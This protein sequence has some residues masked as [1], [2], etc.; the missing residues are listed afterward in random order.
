MKVLVLAN[1][2]NSRQQS[3]QRFAGLIREGLE[4]AGH[5]VRLVRPPVVLGRLRRCETGLA[6]W[7]GYIDRYILFPPLLRWQKRWADVVHIVADA[8]YIP[9]LHGKPYVLTCHDMLAIRAASGEIAAFPTGWTGRIYQ[10]W[11]LRNLRKAQVVA[12]VSQQ[13]GEELQRLAGLAGDRVA[14]VPNALNYPYSPMK[15]DEAMARLKALRLDGTMP[16]LLHVGGNQWYK[17]RPG[18]LRIFAELVKRPGFEPHR[19]VMAGKPWPA[20]LRQLAQEL[21]LQSRALELVEVANED[22]RALYST[23]E[24]LLFPSLQEGFGWPIVE[25]QS[26]GCPVITTNRAP[27]TEVGGDGA[28]YIDPEE[29][30]S[31]ADSIVTALAERER[32]RVAGFQN[33][34]RFSRAAMVAGYV[35]CYRAARQLV[36]NATEKAE[37]VS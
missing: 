20:E 13:T 35:Q 26:C 27:M 31:A 33:A 32:W 29:A 16:F 4:A 1:Y 30:P 5:E 24:A 12:C 9:H 3:M 25:A 28:I 14:V 21:G 34:V 22:L 23:A 19:L 17:N 6:K 15:N 8:V 7:I 11:I 2:E 18:V 36:P 10:R 37:A